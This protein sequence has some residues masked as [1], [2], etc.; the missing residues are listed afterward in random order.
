MDHFTTSFN[1]VSEDGWNWTLLGITGIN[2]AFIHEWLNVAV[3][4]LS[5]I[6]LAIN[7]H[8]NLKNR[9]P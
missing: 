7:I 8:K 4:G 1:Q 9:K 6:A 3:A 5:C 2:A